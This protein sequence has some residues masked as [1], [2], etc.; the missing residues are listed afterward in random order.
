MSQCIPNNKVEI[1]LTSKMLV[2]RDLIDALIA[3]GLPEDVEAN[4]Y[5]SRL[6]VQRA[7]QESQGRAA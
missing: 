4:L 1:R 2:I 7:W 6:H 3:E 5:S